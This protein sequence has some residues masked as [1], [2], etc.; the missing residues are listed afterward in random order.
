[1]E[2]ASAIERPNKKGGELRIGPKLKAAR[3]ARRLSMKDLAERV[4]CSESLISK[5]EN[6]HVYPSLPTLHK[7]A[8]ELGSS[9]GKLIAEGGDGDFISRAGQRP[10]ISVDAIGRNGSV[11][12]KLEGVALN[13]ELLYASIHVIDAGGSS[14]GFIEHV[15]EELAY[16]LEG[17]VEIAIG[18]KIHRLGPHDSI[19][20]PSEMPHGYRNP[21][22]RVARILWVNTPPTF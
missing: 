19:F 2:N 11:G 3:R 7:L 6:D 20:F 13:G 8:A 14:G 21:G 10:I 16:V 12:I 17:E 15:G 5:I 18:D 22:E 4:G 9:I 1:M